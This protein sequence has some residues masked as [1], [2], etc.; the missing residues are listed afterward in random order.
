MPFRCICLPIAAVTCAS[1]PL[2]AQDIDA[3]RQLVQTYC[4]ECHDVGPEGGISPLPGAPPFSTL[5]E[6]YD[7]D[8]LEEALVEGLVTGHE[9]M[10]E[11]EFDP[12]QAR[13]IIDYLQGLETLRI[14]PPGDPLQR[15]ASA[16]FGELTFQFYCSTCHGKEGRADTPAAAMFSATDLGYLASANGGT[17]PT[18]RVRAIIDG[19]ED[20]VGHTGVRM[21]PWARLFAH[22][23]EKVGSDEERERLIALRI[24]DLVAYLQSIQVE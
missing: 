12:S 3:G 13:A 6:R 1:A 8:L 5:H 20:I 24:A 2:L 14:K 23:L 7:V 4:A 16:T 11:F 10:P 21:P 18:E 22:E 9:T 17:F 15:P 19:R